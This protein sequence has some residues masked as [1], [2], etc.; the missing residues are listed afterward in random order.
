MTQ[1]RLEQNSGLSHSQMDFIMKDR[2]KT[3][4]FTTIL[5]LAKG[6]DMSLLEF[7]DSPYF[8]L[9]NLDIE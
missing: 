4:T 2:N 9:D 3:V 8:D 5:L 7:S 6:F 1:Y